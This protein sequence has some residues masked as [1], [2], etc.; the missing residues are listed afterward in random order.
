MS[1]LTI[2]LHSMRDNLEGFRAMYKCKN[3]L[4]AGHRLGQM[5]SKFLHID[6][7]YLSSEAF[8]LSEKLADEI[9]CLISAAYLYQDA[10]ATVAESEINLVISR[11][12]AAI[13]ALK[14][15][16]PASRAASFN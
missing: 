9:S 5:Q 10:V 1:N 2:T 6:R 8:E 15:C 12:H 16:L 13:K 7:M 14:D 3:Y 11:V 4:M